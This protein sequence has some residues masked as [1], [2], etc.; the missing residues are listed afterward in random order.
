MVVEFDG[1]KGLG[2]IKFDRVP[3]WLLA[4]RMPPGM[5][6]SATACVANTRLICTLWF[7]LVMSGC[8]RDS[9]LRVSL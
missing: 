6:N 8:Q 1:K 9:R 3:I 7:G 5:M 2:D 4:S